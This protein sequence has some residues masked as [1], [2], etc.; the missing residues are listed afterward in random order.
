MLFSSGQIQIFRR[1]VRL[2]EFSVAVV[3]EP[4]CDNIGGEERLEWAV[5]FAH[6][7]GI[8]QG[9]NDY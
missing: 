6:G 2:S 8:V 4:S 7:G 3:V 1:I 9:G 5:G